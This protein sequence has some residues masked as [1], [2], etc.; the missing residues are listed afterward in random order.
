MK[1]IVVPIL[2]LLI[3]AQT[4]S[5]WFIVVEYQLNKSYISKNLCVNKSR[6]KLHCNGKCRMM[7]KM[8]EEQQPMNT[9]KIKLQEVV[10]PDQIPSLYICRTPESHLVFTDR[11]V[12]PGYITPLRSIFHPPA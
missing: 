11:Y 7:K 5:K 8:A 10:F 12:I 2:M 1:L 6:P 4:F 9:V 3:S